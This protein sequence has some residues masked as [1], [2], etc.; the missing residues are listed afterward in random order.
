[1]ALPYMSRRCLGNMDK[2][3]GPECRAYAA[4]MLDIGSADMM[5]MQTGANGP[6]ELDHLW[7]RTPHELM[8]GRGAGGEAAVAALRAL[9]SGFVRAARDY[10]IGEAYLL[11]NGL[12]SWR[13]AIEG[14]AGELHLRALFLDGRCCADMALAEAARRLGG[15]NGPRLFI[16]PDGTQTHVISGD[17]R[18]ALALPMGMDRGCYDELIA[19]AREGDRRRL[20]RK[21]GQDARIMLMRDEACSCARALPAS[22]LEGYRLYMCIDMPYGILKQ[23]EY[24]ARRFDGMAEDMAHA[25][26]EA[27]AGVC[28]ALSEQDVCDETYRTSCLRRAHNALCVAS[29]V[30]ARINAASVSVISASPLS[31]VVEA[32]GRSEGVEHAGSDVELARRSVEG[33]ADA[34]GGSIA[35]ALRIATSARMVLRALSAA[36]AGDEFALADELMVLG[37]KLIDCAAVDGEELVA[38]VLR[39]PGLSARMREMLC[40]IC[41]AGRSGDNQLI[42]SSLMPGSRADERYEESMF[43]LDAPLSDEFAPAEDYDPASAY[44]EDADADPADYESAPGAQARSGLSMSADKPL[45]LRAAAILHLALTLDASGRARLSGLTVKLGERGLLLRA[46]LQESAVLETLSFKYR[47]ELFERVFGIKARLKLDK[48][49]PQAR[50]AL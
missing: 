17:G 8:H 44:G 21:D 14:I 11:V 31:A 49:R 1:M 4:I 9:L 7:R 12:E 36:F 34:H 29:A 25:A 19:L 28:Y 3:P 20:V 13:S 30:R 23:G 24:D 22:G 42:Y 47:S 6:E 18:Y 37:S 38:A 5:I 40:A 35:R 43:A 48:R 10:G 46:S 27:G 39:L 15:D 16:I 33:Y 2:D 26:M 41:A 32:L 45:A 50:Q